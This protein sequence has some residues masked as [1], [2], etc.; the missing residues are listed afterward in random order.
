[1]NATIANAAD[2]RTVGPDARPAVASELL[3]VGAV[4]ALLGCSKRTVYRLSD[5]SRMPRPLKLGQLVRWRRA[6]VLAWIAGGCEP[7]RSA[8]GAAR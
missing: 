7:V 2:G 5:G 3:D 1:M 8:K 6:E 4:A